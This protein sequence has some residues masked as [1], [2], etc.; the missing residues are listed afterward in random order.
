MK[1]PGN[2][3][4]VRLGVAR[5]GLRA[6][7]SLTLAACASLPPADSVRVDDA[8]ISSIH[9]GSAGPTIVFQS[10]LG[11]GKIV[12]AAVLQR[13]SASDSIF[14]YD[15]PG[16]G[17][18][19]T[20]LKARDACTV[21]TELHDTLH[22][23][24]LKPPYILVGHSLGGLYQYAYLKLYPDEVAGLLLLDPTH[25]QHWVTMQQRT[26]ASA[27]V[28]KAMRQTLFSASMQREFD[29]QSVCL[30]QLRERA[31]PSVPARLLVRSNFEL[32]E[33]GAFQSMTRELEQDWLQLL[34]GMTRRE[35]SSSGHYI[36][37][38]RPDV[39]AEEIEQL[40][41]RVR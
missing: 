23:A 25:P 26:P 36:Q 4:E 32:I 31:T 30:A 29:D 21:A 10:G 3:R 28:L 38:D 41:A 15:R 37:R 27:G 5:W 1:D 24:R 6:V 8:D 20:S 13:Q 39:V 19:S 2:R 18:S 22:A 33:L 40:R 16:Y 35:V 14:A 17:S 12:W 11:D 34:P 7:L 9:R